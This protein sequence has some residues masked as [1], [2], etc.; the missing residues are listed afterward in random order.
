M[1]DGS[2]APIVVGL[3]GSPTSFEAVRWAAAE[4]SYRNA[5]LRVVHADVSELGYVPETL[6][7]SR[8][9]PY[10]QSPRR[11]VEEWLTM[12]SE[13]AGEASGQLSVDTE[14]RSSSARTALIEESSTAALVVVGSRGLGAFSS[15]V[16]GSVAIALCQHGHC[17]VA[18]IREP[19]AAAEADQ[20][21]VVVGVDGSRAGELALRWGFET[22]SARSAT[23]SVVHAWHDLVVGELWTTAQ[24]DEVWESVRADEQRLLS[25]MLAGWRS[26]YPDV[27]VQEHISYGKP[28]KVLL[29]Q[30][31]RARLMVV[32]ARGR[33]GLAGLLLGSTSQTLLHHAPCP[34]IVA[35]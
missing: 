11:Q 32:G 21:P 27:P 19:D 33:G 15:L 28:T 3:D 30:A 10:S 23:L 6:S 1:S 17:P 16:L 14:I 7:T 34:V 35:R 12:A 31:Q 2:N 9:E 13:I 8:R 20:R 25:E 4:A 29:E 26:D 22:A 24:A 18:V 5:R